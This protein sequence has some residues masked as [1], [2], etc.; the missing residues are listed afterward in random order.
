MK[1]SGDGGREEKALKLNKRITYKIILHTFPGLISTTCELDKDENDILVSQLKK[2]YA[3]L[4][5]LYL[6]STFDLCDTAPRPSD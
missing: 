6:L 1:N 2:S 3:L 4:L 5:Y